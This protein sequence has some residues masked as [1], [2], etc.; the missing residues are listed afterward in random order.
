MTAR[1]A[2]ARPAGLLEL[3]M[4]V[5]RPEFRGE[6]FVPPHGHPVFVQGECRIAACPTALTYARLRLCRTHYQHWTGAGRPE[7]EA[8]TASE[9]ERLRGR[10]EVPRCAV[11]GC[12]RAAASGRLCHR[13]SAAWV[14]AGR[15]GLAQWLPGTPYQPPAPHKSERDCVFPGCLRW[16]DGPQAALCHRHHVRWHKHSRPDLDIWLA[17]LAGR[18]D[19]RVKLAGLDPQLRLEV[20]FGLQCRADEGRKLTPPRDVTR[21]VTMITDAQT[22]SL[23]DWDEAAWRDWAAPRTQARRPGYNTVAFRFI[24]DTCFQLQRLLIAEDP[25]ADQY[26]RDTWDLCLLGVPVEDTVRYLRFGPVRQPWLR[27]LVRRWCRW[28]LSRGLSPGTVA[29]DL[30]ACRM[31]AARLDPGITADQVSRELIESWVAWLP[32]VLPAVNS[33]RSAVNSLGCFLADVH[34]HGWEPGLPRTTV[35][36]QDAPRGG[37]SRPRWIAEHLMR[38]MEAPESLA[39]VPSD[40]GRLLTRLL[41]ACGLRLKDA[42]RL[43]FDCV[44]RDD[45]GAPYLAWVNHKMRGRAAFFPISA[46]LA[47]QI[48][49]WQQQVLARYPAGCPFLFPGQVCNLNGSKPV[50]ATW[51]QEQLETWLDRIR[52]TDEHGRPVRVTAH[53]FRHT[54]GTRLI[55]ANVP[56]HVVQQLLDHMSPAMTAIYARLHDKTIRE[57]WEKAVKVGADGQPVTVPAGHP[58]AGAAWMRHSMVRAKVTLPNG[59]CGAPVQTDCE[60]AN[61]CLDCRFFITTAGFLDQHRQQRASTEQAIADARQAGL[62][63][64]AEKNRRTLDRL[65]TIITALE[66]AGPGQVVAGGKVTGLDAAR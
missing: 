30:N 54:L 55:N 41:I 17:G 14:N 20:G 35:V 34:R 45:S 62:A 32:G 7:L 36:Y 52:L 28:R 66:Q 40:D 61:P 44:T 10:L 65:G 23:L 9:S 11:G 6:V 8:W 60:Y 53:Q 58:L 16:T 24:A 5:V 31:F 47:G 59:Y 46:E 26:P 2:N 38:Q 19:P 4:E 57:H 37:P 22:A 25:W 49:S 50:S 15:P 43:P 42:R 1:K 33:R 21:A 29:D 51:Y 48:T 12:N 63:R 27:D 18:G 3:L 13:H 56:Q 39:Q 64:V